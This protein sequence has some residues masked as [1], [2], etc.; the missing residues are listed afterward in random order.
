MTIK[1][2]ITVRL[3]QK[4]Y[5]IIVTSRRYTSDDLI[6]YALIMID[7]NEEIIIVERVA[8][9]TLNFLFSLI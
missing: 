7:A 5:D 1:I 3:D 9:V 2:H 8:D 6:V 4:Q